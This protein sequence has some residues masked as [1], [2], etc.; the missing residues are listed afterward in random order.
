MACAV[1][2]EKVMLYDP[3]WLQCTVCGAPLTEEEKM[4]DLDSGEQEEECFDCR[5]AP[6]AHAEY[7]LDEL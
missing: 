6:D 3:T 4:L 5:P 1:L 7:T 2:E